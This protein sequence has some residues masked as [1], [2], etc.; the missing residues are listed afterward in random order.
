M[1]KLIYSEYSLL[2]SHI[3]LV[4]NKSGEGE[5]LKKKIQFFSHKSN[6]GGVFFLFLFLANE[7]LIFVF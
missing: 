7:E 3:K 1:V 4:C 5:C 6:Y 2:S